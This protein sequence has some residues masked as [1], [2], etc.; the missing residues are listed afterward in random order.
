MALEKPGGLGEFL[1]YFV[2]TLDVV[3]YCCFV[4]R[5][6]YVGGDGGRLPAL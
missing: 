4:I 3:D 1:S 6:Y 2:A 5:A